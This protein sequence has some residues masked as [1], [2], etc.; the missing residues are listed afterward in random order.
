MET[1]TTV[2]VNGSFTFPEETINFTANGGAAVHATRERAHASTAALIDVRR[3]HR[4]SAW[5]TS[6]SENRLHGNIPRKNESR[7]ENIFSFEHNE[8][9]WNI[10]KFK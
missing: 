1:Q 8:I 3:W 7:L 2:V 10:A 9:Y 4:D 5:R 6:Q